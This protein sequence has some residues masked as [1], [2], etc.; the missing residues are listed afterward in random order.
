M[1][2]LTPPEIYKGLD[3][4]FHFDFD[5]CPYPRPKGFD[6]LQVE[7]GKSNYVNPLFWTGGKRGQGIT[8]WVRKALA[9]AE[10]GKTSVLTLPLDGWVSLLLK[11]K[12]ID[13]RPRK[14]WYWIT[15][16]GEKRKPS[17]PLIVFVVR[18]KTNK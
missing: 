18:P 6:G 3:D 11:D 2:I 14:D 5:P 1:A 9:E 8:Y 17:R 7:W 16:K 13:I 12:N 10:K 15:P 4:E